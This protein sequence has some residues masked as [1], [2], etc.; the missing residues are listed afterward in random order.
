MFE[1]GNRL[2]GIY[3]TNDCTKHVVIDPDCIGLGPPLPA[4]RKQHTASDVENNSAV[5]LKT[6]IEYRS[7]MQSLVLLLSL[8][9]GCSFSSNI[10]GYGSKGH[11]GGQGYADRGT[12]FNGYAQ[13]YDG[14]AYGGNGAEYSGHGADQSGHA[15]EYAAAGKVHSGADYGLAAGYDKNSQV[16]ELSGYGKDAAHKSFGS[17]DYKYKA[18]EYHVES[19][20]SEEKDG[21]QYGHDARNQGYSDQGSAQQHGTL[22]EVDTEVTTT[23]MPAVRLLDTANSEPSTVIPAASVGTAIGVTWPRPEDMD[24]STTDTARGPAT[25]PPFTPPTPVGRRLSGVAGEVDRRAQLCAVERAKAAQSAPPLPLDVTDEERRRNGCRP[26][27]ERA[28]QL[29]RPTAHRR[30]AAYHSSGGCCAFVLVAL[31]FAPREP[32]AVADCRI[33]RSPLQGQ[34]ASPRKLL[35]DPISLRLALFQRSSAAVVLIGLWLCPEQRCRL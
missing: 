35:I 26:E 32:R 14:S 22:P 29:L 8:L 31:L 3:K 34:V 2:V 1:L 19:Y 9:V 28:L 23:A 17:Y 6:L 25:A 12:D 16:D 11:T 27:D 24:T 18:P 20:F 30:S 5:A 10:G 15:Q 21:K 4:V 7:V 13:G 33:R